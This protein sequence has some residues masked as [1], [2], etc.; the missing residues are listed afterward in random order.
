MQEVSRQRYTVCLLCHAKF[1]P[2]HQIPL[3][4]MQ[5]LSCPANVSTMLRILH[6]VCMCTYCMCSYVHISYIATVYYS[7]VDAKQM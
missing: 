6:T 2:V 3:L 1:T 4:S 7:Y 5:A